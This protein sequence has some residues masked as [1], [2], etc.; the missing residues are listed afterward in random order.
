MSLTLFTLQAGSALCVCCVLISTYYKCRREYKNDVYNA[1]QPYFT[2]GMLT[3][4]I[5][6]YEL[7]N[8]C[9]FH[10]EFK[11]IR[12]ISKALNTHWF[13]HHTGLHIIGTLKG[14]IILQSNIVDVR[15][16]RPFLVGKMQSTDAEIENH[17]VII[18]LYYTTYTYIYILLIIHR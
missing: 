8:K 17:L 9:I 3:T 1:A 7:Y 12:Q 6:F 11:K 2:N 18:I 14:T 13:P 5:L 16:L 15:S 4:V 10:C